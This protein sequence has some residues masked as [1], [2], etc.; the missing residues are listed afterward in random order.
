M[1]PGMA[2][3]N[4]L[5]PVAG[6]LKG[7]VGSPLP[8]VQVRLVDEHEAEIGTNSAI[9]TDHDDGILY[10]HRYQHQLYA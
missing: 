4:P 2:L 7:H 3:S 8:L 1:H 6:R 9:I 5:E 10:L